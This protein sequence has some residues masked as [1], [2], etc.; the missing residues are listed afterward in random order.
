MVSVFF[1][2]CCYTRLSPAKGM[3]TSSTVRVVLFLA[4]W[5]T[6]S[7]AQHNP[8]PLACPNT[9]TD[10]I[11]ID[12]IIEIGE[13][14]SSTLCNADAATCRAYGHFIWI[15]RTPSA[16]GR[17]VSGAF[18]SV[19]GGPWSAAPSPATIF[20]GHSLPPATARCL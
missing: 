4:T 5:S 2:F 14:S 10:P 8:P 1:P 11:L 17:L 15:A 16:L 3:L 7:H 19:N 6:Y 9:L 18:F 12:P 20:Q 13:D